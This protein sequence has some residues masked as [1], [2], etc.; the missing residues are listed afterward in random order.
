MLLSYRDMKGGRDSRMFD[1]C[2]APRPEWSKTSEER[3]TEA[4]G[5]GWMDGWMERRRDG[6]RLGI[7]R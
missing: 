6:W 2:P 1:G 3:K 4:G 5:K 7:D